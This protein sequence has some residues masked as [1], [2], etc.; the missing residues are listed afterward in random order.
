[1]PGPVAIER[2]VQGKGKKA[3]IVETADGRRMVNKRDRT[4]V[5]DEGV[6]S[7]VSQ[8]LQTVV[9]DGTAERAQIPGVM[10]AGKTGTTESYGDAWFVGWTKEY[11]VAV[12][13]GYPDEFKPMETEFQGEPV[14]GGTFPTA[15]W[16]SFMMSP[17]GPP[18]RRHARQHGHRHEQAHR[19]QDG[20]RGQRRDAEH[21]GARQVADGQRDREARRAADRGE[22]QGLAGDHRHHV[23]PRRPDGDANADLPCSPAHRERQQ[24]EQSGGREQQR[25]RRDGAG[26]RDRPLD[27]ARGVAGPAIERHDAVASAPT[28]P[29]PAGRRGPPG[30]PRRRHERG[31]SKTGSAARPTPSRDRPS[32]ARQARC[33]QRC[34]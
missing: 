34:R 15:I 10:V 8:I 33:P 28:D 19:R 12:W 24:R 32:A 18:R 30:A 16:K 13:V 5:M 11:T 7:Q 3:K 23:E 4:R 29:R 6:A 25:E 9:K 31:P 14:A 20:T 1:M 17:Q 21:G 2:I 22:R 27:A 26:E